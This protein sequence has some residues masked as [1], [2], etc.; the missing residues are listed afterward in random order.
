[1]GTVVKAH[2][3][4]GEVVVLPETDSAE[5]FSPGSRLATST[6][7]ALTV[8]SCVVG[9][10]GW[11]IGFLEVGDRDQAESLVGAELLVESTQRRR[12]EAGEYW[13]DQLIGLEVRSRDGSVLG[14]VKAVDDRTA[15]ARLIVA[16]P[17][18]EFEV[19]FVD[20]LVPEV[21]DGYLV[22][23]RSRF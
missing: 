12:L 15:Q 1:M 9:E 18:G 23:E 8:R 21:G 17:G 2:G 20:E 22:V 16:V 6:D 7:R 5:R 19:P 14:R 10:R 3:I 4:K 13:P 11:L